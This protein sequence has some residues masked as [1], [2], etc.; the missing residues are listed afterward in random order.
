MAL[1]CVDFDHTLV[2]GDT[3]IAGAREAINILREH[4]HKILVYS[5]NGLDWIKK[6]LDNADIRYD[7]I[8]T[9]KSKPLADLYVDDRGYHFRG[10]WTEELPDILTRVNGLDNRKW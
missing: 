5:C 8:W 3:P 6:C 7:S 2:H 4:G 10:N 1:I 9:D